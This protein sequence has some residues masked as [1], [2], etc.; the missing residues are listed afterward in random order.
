MIERPIL[1][2]G[3]M[4]RAILAGKK[5]QTRRI[6]KEPKVARLFGRR[7]IPERHHADGPGG[8]AGPGEMYLHWFYGGGDMAGDECAERVFC[9]YGQPGDRLW[10]RENFA[11]PHG[12]D[13]LPPRLVVARTTVHYEASEPLGGLVLRPSIFLPRWASRITLAI[14][15]VRVE[16]LQD[17]TE[18]A[19]LAEGVAP[20][21][22]SETWLYYDEVRRT[23]FETFAPNE[24]VVTERLLAHHPPELLASARDAFAQG[25]NDL[26]GKRG[27]WSS[28]PWVWVVTFHREVAP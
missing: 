9:P 3:A 24:P 2:S 27:H 23:T 5:T 12:C 16:K 25:W 14:E 26:N 18:E 20:R 7:S 8:F 6:V 19:A 15:T 11:F 28:N 22:S 1:F 17:L 21:L 4:V 10:V 13:H